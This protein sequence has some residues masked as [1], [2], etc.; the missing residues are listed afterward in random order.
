MT[1][2]AIDALDADPA[3]R[4]VVL[5]S[6]PPHAEVARRVLDRIAASTKPFTVCFI[7]G[8]PLVLPAN[9]SHAGTLREAAEQASGGRVIGS[10]F[11]AGQI[12][13]ACVRP[14]LRI[15]GLFCGGTLC[16]EAQVVLR[17]L[18]RTPLS[19]TPIPGVDRLAAG[20]A[21][22]R[23][24]DLGADEY[25]RGRPHPMIDPE[26]RDET[27][28]AALADRSV[29]VVLLDVVIGVGAHADPAGLS[30]ATLASRR[31]HG[32]V[33]VASVTGTEQDPQ[34]R[35]RQVERLQAAGALVAPC[36][37]QAAELAVAIVS[38]TR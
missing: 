23:L 15:E 25:T 27:L 13:A 16:A 3:T 18:G 26:V 31:D 14:G 38:G 17:R 4:H 6:K 24:L 12:A 20:A 21:N 7:G 10:G 19:N 2:M 8:E 9:A 22:D 5:I 32:P 30:S 29:G 1:L 36:N 35:S 11:D 37:A 28:R 33:V 34:V